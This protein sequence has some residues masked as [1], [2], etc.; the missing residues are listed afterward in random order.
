MPSCWRPHLVHWSVE[1]KSCNNN[2]LQ[3]YKHH[4]KIR[5]RSNLHDL[6]REPNFFLVRF[7]ALYKRLE[8]IL[9]RP[10]FRKRRQAAFAFCMNEHSSV[11]VTN[12]LARVSCARG[13]IFSPSLPSNNNCQ[14]G[15]L[16]LFVL[17]QSTL[18]PQTRR[19]EKLCTTLF[20]LRTNL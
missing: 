3:K 14:I 16:I 5:S 8:F 10:F 18:N 7:H 1:Q 9:F 4:T 20:I 12:G 19:R 15:W 11:D 6:P 2:S 17:K 13:Q